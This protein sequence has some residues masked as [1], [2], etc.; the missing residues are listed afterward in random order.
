MMPRIEPPPDVVSTIAK[1]GLREQAAP[2]LV[3]QID[4]GQSPFVR[5]TFPLLAPAMQIATGSSAVL[6]IPSGPYRKVLSSAVPHT[7]SRPAAT[8]GSWRGF[9]NRGQ[10]S[11][12]PVTGS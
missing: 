3:W 7:P 1:S 2:T 11:S 9:G 8:S 4:A 5:Q 12:A 6:Q 10:L